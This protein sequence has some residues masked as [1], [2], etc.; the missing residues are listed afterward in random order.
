M[1]LTIIDILFSLGLTLGVGS[2][3]FAL[4]FFIKSLKDGVMDETERSF[5]RVVFTVLRIGMVLIAVG[6]AGFLLVGAI[7]EQTAYLLEC[8]LLFI[9]ILNAVLM[10]KRIMPM[11]FGPIIAGGSWYSLFFVSKLPVSAYSY[12]T[13]AAAYVVF[14]IVFYFAFN[15]I[16]AAYAA[17]KV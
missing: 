17:P 11:K 2:S 15:A 10:D 3:T 4:I 9:I 5:L 8:V 12:A 13:V 16:K 7:P 1:E 6:L 14:L